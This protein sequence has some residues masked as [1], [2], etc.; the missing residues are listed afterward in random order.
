[1]TDRG[2][3]LKSLECYD[4]AIIDYN[5]ALSIQPNDAELLRSRGESYR[6]RSKFDESVRL[7]PQ[8]FMLLQEE[9]KLIVC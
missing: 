7:N 8:M 9:V 2:K 3:I 1:M 6:L 5:V 4:R